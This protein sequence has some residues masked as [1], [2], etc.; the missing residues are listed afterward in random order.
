MCDEH[1]QDK[2]RPAWQKYVAKQMSDVISCPRCWLGYKINQTLYQL[3][4]HP[5]E[6]FCPRCNLEL[7]LD[8][9]YFGSDGL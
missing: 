4:E 3:G 2:V 6:L 1:L 7:V 5:E 8:I 9:R